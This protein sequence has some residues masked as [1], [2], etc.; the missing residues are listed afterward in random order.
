MS[1]AAL[2]S[3]TTVRGQTI[4]A[5][6]TPVATAFLDVNSVRALVGNNGRLFWPGSGPGVYEIGGAA[7]IFAA[8]LSFAGR[9]EGELRASVGRFGS[10]L[11]AGPVFPNVTA[12]PDCDRFDRIY[13]I[14]RDDIVRF[15]SEGI[16]TRDLQD[17]PTGLGAPTR[18]VEGNRIVLRSDGA[19]AF[20][21]S[22]DEIVRL[23]EMS[24]EE[25]LNRVIDLAAGERPVLLGDQML[26]WVMNDLGNVNTSY[27][28]APPVGAEVHAT[29]FGF[30]VPGAI[31]NT[32][33]YKYRLIYKG[34]KSLDSSFVGIW[35][36]GD[37]GNPGDD[38]VG[39][40]TTL[41]L[42]FSYNADDDDEGNNGYG[43]APPAFGLDF[44]QGP[45]VDKD[46]QDN[47]G[48]GMSD[49]V[50][51]RLQMTS[52]MRLINAGSGG[53]D[54]EQDPFTAD[55]YYNTLQGKW[56]DGVPMTVGGRGRDFSSKRTTFQFSGA[57]ER[58]EFWSENNSD[59]EG[60]ALQA[61]DRRFLVSTGP[62]TIE[63][64]GDQEVV[65]GIVWARGDDHLDS[66]RKLKEEDV[67]AQGLFDIDFEVARPPDPPRVT[68]TPLA[69][70]VILE[71]SYKPTDN[72]YLD[73]YRAVDPLISPD[74]SD[75]DYVLEGYKVFQ[76]T[77]PS[78]RRG[79]LL[80]TYDVPNGVTEVIEGRDLTFLT[81]E[82]TDSGLQHHHVV[83]DLTNYRTYYFG[84]Q[85]YAYNA[86]SGSRVYPGPVRRVE[87][88]PTRSDASNGGSALDTDA[89]DAATDA[90]NAVGGDIVAVADGRGGGSVAVDIVNPAK[91][92]GHDYQVEF[93]E[94][95]SAAKARR[96]EIPEA[97]DV[98][99][100]SAR[101]Q[102][103]RVQCV[104]TYNIVDE[105]LNQVIFDG[106]E[107]ITATGSAA[108]QGRNVHMLDGM[109]F[110]IE[111]PEPGPLVIDDRVMFV[112]V[113][114]PGGVD[115][116]GPSAF[117]VFGCEE[118]GGN[119]VYV[120][121]NSTGQYLMNSLFTGPEGSIGNFA[122]NDYEIRFTP[123][124]SY[125]VY[126][127]G[128]VGDD[129]GDNHIRVPFEVWDVGLVGAH[130]QNDPSD[131]VRMI[132]ALWSLGESDRVFE[133]GEIGA[134]DGEFG[135][136]E[137][138]AAYAYYPVEGQTYADW[139]A[140]VKPNVDTALNGVWNDPDG[141]QWDL[142]DFGRGRPI[143]RI[144]FVDNQTDTL[145]NFVG[146]IADLEG[147]VIRFLT[148]KP[149]LPGD[150]FSFT[151]EGYQ[152]ETGNEDIAHEALK[153]IGIVPNPYKGASAYEVSR[154]TD[155]VRF[156]NMPEL[157]TVRVFDLA[158][159]LVRRMTKNS[160]EAF[161][162]WDLRTDE[163]L[164]IGSGI[165]F[166][167]VEVPGIGERVLKFAA[168]MKGAR[169]DV[170]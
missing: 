120:S 36:D 56:K 140:I 13:K 11:W 20:L 73:S 104:T 166:I 108:P 64:G 114:G 5:C 126:P 2:F 33:F 131:D 98:I 26:W 129:D 90:P 41:G 160:P 43:A 42:G 121:L 68:A 89:I 24:F 145:D 81:A 142:I 113:L 50:G 94:L 168:V 151:T 21:G 152:P 69:E 6:K 54:F 14:N 101:S 16:A 155:Q 135:R 85:A 15:D 95:C 74:I 167:H 86:E 116:C 40:D 100:S 130:G 117:S 46:G 143:Q 55:E 8:H 28:E 93:L 72:N 149:N 17:W 39:V 161:F 78:D 35:V 87:V 30:N 124:G 9:V 27:P 128:F 23:E 127:F 119:W 34:E 158:G 148:A 99:P 112:E 115:P 32:T 156:T 136:P 144:T 29:A 70:K 91:I 37:L 45:L 76:F 84:V 111:G 107:A 49:E 105:T 122:P 44:F 146:R 57:P 51:E 97:R 53:L 71:W 165:Y 164:P 139:E 153:Q 3:S 62:F 12:P 47:D 38:Y 61:A 123:E 63:P 102:A 66:V 118:V 169:L 125:G 65:F 159:T 147:V 83:E 19:L 103:G 141:Q 133:F 150:I 138:D 157:A 96:E 106:A 79:S 1:C 163:G 137:T 25:R 109:A 67:L 92:T 162:R 22:D 4:G 170:F 48:D 60:S 82:G 58:N 18:D 59:G 75:N 77:D 132:P 31:G 134:E 110:H 88:V 7:S 80:A 10:S 52:F 154:Q